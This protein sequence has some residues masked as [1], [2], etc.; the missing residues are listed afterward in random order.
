MNTFNFQRFLRV[1]G[2]DLLLLNGRRVAMITLALM[3]LGLLY[4]VTNVA[5]ASDPGQE[6]M[7]HAM[8]PI[9]LLLGG[10]IFT[11][12]IYADLHHP[13]ERFHYLTLPVSNLERFLSRYLIT[14]PFYYV[15]AVVVF[16]VFELI[17][18]AV[19]AAGWDLT[20]VPMDLGNDF[21]KMVSIGYFAS[22]ALMYTGAIYFR[23]YAF[24]RTQASLAGLWLACIVMAGGTIRLLYWDMFEPFTFFEIKPEAEGNVN[25]GLPAF[26]DVESGWTLLHK[27]IATAVLAWVLFLGYLGLRH[28]EVQ[29]G[30]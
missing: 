30:L 13:L 9:L 15:Y 14:A 4:Y 17:A 16:Y 24:I 7:S 19:I 18:A 10:S 25:I 1:I 11:S 21:M 22:H 20:F 5:T 26:L 29:D 3:G 8:F 23:S 2:N 28:H 12:M 6:P 27:A